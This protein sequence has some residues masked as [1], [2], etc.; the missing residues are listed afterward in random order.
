MNGQLKSRF[1]F[2]R[3]LGNWGSGWQDE[4]QTFPPKKGEYGL[5]QWLRGKESACQG[6]RCRRWGF[7]PRVRK[8]PWRGKRQPIPIFLSGKS[9][10]SRSPAGYSPWGHRES[11]TVEH[12]CTKR[13]NRRKLLVHREDWAVWGEHYPF[14]GFDLKASNWWKKWTWDRNFNYNLMFVENYVELKCRRSL[15][16]YWGKEKNVLSFQEAWENKGLAELKI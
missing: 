13:R 11:D 14:P 7:N 3:L 5:P 9:H 10:G 12:A 1:S 15:K 6:R 8:I 2:P 16:K 4:A